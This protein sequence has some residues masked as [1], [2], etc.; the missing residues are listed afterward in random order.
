MFGARISVTIDLVGA[1]LSFFPGSPAQGCPEVS[2]LALSPWLL[3]PT[4]FVVV[5]ILAFNFVGDRLR[6]AADPHAHV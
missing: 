6:N 2:V 3:L 1:A 4:I 5:T